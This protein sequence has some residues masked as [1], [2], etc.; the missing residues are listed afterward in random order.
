VNPK[1]LD[2]VAY[3]LADRDA[4]AEFVVRYLGMHVIDRTDAFTLVGADARRGKLTLFAADGPRERG[5]LEHVTLR[6]GD[7]ESALAR[8]PVGLEAERRR[9]GEAYFELGEGVVLGLVE[10]DTDL[11][12]DLDHV[13]LR[14]ADPQATA[15]EY[16][17]LGFRAAA[18]GA[19]RCPR[20]EVGGAWIE[21]Q[22]GEPGAPE[23]PLLNH[24]AVLVDSADEHEAAARDLG[25]EID[26]VV[27]A[28]NTLAV[29]VW[30][31]ERVRIEY[32]EHKPTFSLT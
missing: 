8:L 22:P 32:V 2:H 28:P 21:F 9:A 20:V 6:V 13:A 12:Y 15:S 31:P 11:D 25:V 17:S 19:S 7:L 1:I 4:V 5:A 14:S 24:L 29:F 3:W 16:E 26:N 27:D 30:G 18:P 23:R 10:A